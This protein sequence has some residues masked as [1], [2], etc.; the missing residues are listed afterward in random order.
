MSYSSWGFYPKTNNT[1]LE[2]N[3]LSE[4]FSLVQT[5]SDFIAY[6]N[7]R[8]YGDSALAK[9][10]ISMKKLNEIISFDVVNGIIFVQS[11]ILLSEILDYIVPKG[12]FLKI[13]P[14]TKLITVGG[15]IA[16]DVHGKNHHID[17][18]VHRIPR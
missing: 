11:G 14:G 8:S 13:T 15:A 3:N 10:I 6:G 9:K 4:L 5:N 18:I 7:G 1:E 12:W 2:Y 17:E 16:S